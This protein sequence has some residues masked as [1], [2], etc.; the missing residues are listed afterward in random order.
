M[1]KNELSRMIDLIDDKYLHEVANS[2]R[3]S[4]LSWRAMVISAACLAIIIF[5]AASL[6]ASQKSV[7]PSDAVYIP[8]VEIAEASGYAQSDMLGFIVYDGRVYTQA[9]YIDYSESPIVKNLADKYLGTASDNI[10]DSCVN[11]PPSSDESQKDFTSSVPGDVYSVKGYD[12][13]FRI[14][15]PEMYEGCGFMAFFECLNDISFSRGSEIF[16]DRLQLRENLSGVRQID[17]DSGEKSKLS[18]SKETTDKFFRAL[19]DSKAVASLDST[20]YKLFEFA[21]KDGTAVML[22]LYEGGFAAYKGCFVKFS[23]INAFNLL[24]EYK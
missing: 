18:L 20:E 12:K 5:G 2:S 21:V 6:S 3:K 15:I 16:G 13:T 4:N 24:Y 23:D 11:S 14:C 9:Q 7:K 1:N 22:R 17:A 19:Y 10:N 8:K